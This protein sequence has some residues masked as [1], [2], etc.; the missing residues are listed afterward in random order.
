MKTKNYF[1]KVAILLL[2]CSAQFIMAQVP[3]YVPTDGLVAYYPFN[4]NANDVSVN[5]NNGINNGA[6]LITDRF[7]NADS[8][9]FFNGS[10]DY[11]DVPSNN[12]FNFQ[13]NNSFTLSYWINATSI[14]TSKV[15]VII[16]KQ[17]GAG[18]AS[19]D[20]WNSNV[21]VN[22]AINL[23]IQNAP[24][25]IFC[26]PSSNA[27]AISNL[28]NYHITQVFQN[29]TSYVY[30]NGIQVSTSTGCLGIIG[31]NSSNMFI[32]KPTW[33]SGNS[34]GFNG[35]IDD[36]GIWNRVLTQQEITA[37]HNGDTTLNPFCSTDTFETIPNININS[38][39]AV[40]YNNEI[41]TIDAFITPKKLSKYNPSTGIVTTV[42]NPSFAT[43]GE[44]SLVALN[45]KLYCFGGW[46]GSAA[47]NKAYVYDVILQ[48]WTSLPNLPVSI[49]QTSAVVLN[50]DIYITGGTLGFTQQYFIKYNPITTNYTILSVPAVQRLNSKLVVYNNSIYCLGG[51][52]SIPANEVNN[53]D[54]YNVLSN[55]WSALPVMPVGLTKVAATVKGNYLYAFGG[56][57]YNGAFSIQ[58]GY[59]AYD[60]INSNWITSTETIPGNTDQSAAVT[61]NDAIYIVNANYSYKY[62]CDNSLSTNEFTSKKT[63]TLYPN[64]TKAILN[65][66]LSEAISATAYEIYNILGEKVGYGNL[67]T[68]SISVSN[69]ANG[70]YIVK[71]NTSE[72]VLTEKFIKE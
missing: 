47:S 41:Y 17:L 32:G 21:E 31:D 42:S 10:T 35:V 4:G 8:A 2:L 46:T 1:R 43:L 29:G 11:I 67:H 22:R 66:T 38:N 7:G 64:P 51:H 14:N 59:M 27:S 45:D 16:N 26:D 55:T 28:T 20:G 53:F 18:T 48:T 63:I 33:I 57:T 58:Y 37:L 40:L 13:T 34:Q 60:F 65:F 52:V 50:G 3:S 49:T 56:S 30:I 12:T 6:I 44:T 69:L 70:V 9:Y 39:D 25:T 36:I 19:Q 15:N 23:R 68:N 24:S 72:G 71:I 5:A 54:T 61:I 62:F